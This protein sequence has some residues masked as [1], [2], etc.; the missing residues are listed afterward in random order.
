MLAGIALDFKEK[1]ELISRSGATCHP[2]HF[3]FSRP[4]A[5][6]REREF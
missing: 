1:G 2:H 4:A 5:E 3:Q 6:R